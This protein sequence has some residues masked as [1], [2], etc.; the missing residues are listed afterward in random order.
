MISVLGILDKLN[1]FMQPVRDWIFENH[2]NPLL[3]IVLFVGGLATF[4]F[5]YSVLQ[6][7]K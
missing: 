6:K 5:T 4:L 2:N 1:E 7:E 3:W